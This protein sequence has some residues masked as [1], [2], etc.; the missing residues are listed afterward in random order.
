M[1]FLDI[2]ENPDI[3]RLIYFGLKILDLI[4][5]IVPLALIIYITIDIFKVIIKA[6]DK[7]IK[8][9]HKAIINRIIF[10]I[11]LFFVPTI[12]TT[13]M[14]VL[15]VS[16][17]T[18]NYKSCINNAT[19]ERINELQ[20]FE[21]L[22]E[23]YENKNPSTIATGDIYND[24]ANEMVRIANAEIGYTEGTNKDNKFGKSLNINNTNWCTLFVTWVAKKT[25]VEDTNLYN[26][27]I[28]SFSGFATVRNTILYFNNQDNLNFYYS[29]H[30]GGNYTPKAGD[31]I[32]FDWESSWNKKISDESIK[33]ISDHEG[34]VV[35]VK[36][37][38]V[39]T[40]EGN[41]GNPKGVRKKSYKLNSSYIMGYGSW[42]N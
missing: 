16:N 21:D 22:K 30:Y 27:V 4:F 39:Y 23:Q 14:N 1:Y 5:L 33:G 2:C 9:S 32:F 25:T 6:D 35:E 41:S 18:T 10:A 3:L 42:Y 15:S 19:K 29:K 40:I 37:G 7:V 26:D 11:A 17:M 34:I 13:V 36:N 38:I 24:L 31:Y 8:E 12:V 28:K 20:E